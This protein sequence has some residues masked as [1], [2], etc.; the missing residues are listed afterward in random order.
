MLKTKITPR[1]RL[2]RAERRANRQ[3]ARQV[4]AQHSELLLNEKT[5]RLGMVRAEQRLRELKISMRKLKP[6]FDP[7]PASKVL[8][9][10]RPIMERIFGIDDTKPRPSYGF[11][12]AMRLA[13]RRAV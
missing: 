6:K 2:Q 7:V 8:P 5:L 13:S 11:L 4:M 12:R 3:L 1:K 9:D 10:R